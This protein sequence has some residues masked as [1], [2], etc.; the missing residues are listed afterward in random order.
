M[1][2]YVYV[3]TSCEDYGENERI[4]NVHLSS[5]SADIE[6]IVQKRE[7]PLLHFKVYKTELVE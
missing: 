2:I 6:A 5:K 1:T 7:R 3:L 4:L